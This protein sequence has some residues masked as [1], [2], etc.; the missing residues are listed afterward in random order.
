MTQPQPQLQPQTVAT[1]DDALAFLDSAVQVAPPTFNTS[2][3]APSVAAI[4]QRL[5]SVHVVTPKTPQ[6]INSLTR[7]DTDRMDPQVAKFFEDFKNLDVGS[8]EFQDQM[9]KVMAAG[10]R[11]ATSSLQLNSS[12]LKGNLTDV[13]TSPAAKALLELSAKFDELDPGKQGDFVK[14]GKILGIIPMP[15]YWRL[16]RYMKKYQA[17]DKTLRDLTGQLQ[18]FEHESMERLSEM[19]NVRKQMWRNIEKLGN[20]AYLKGQLVDKMKEYIAEVGQTDPHKAKVLNED[21]LYVLNQNL[22]DVLSAQMLAWNAYETLGVLIKSEQEISNA[23]NRMATYG[24]NAL[25]IGMLLARATVKQAETMKAVETARNTVHTMLSSQGQMMAEHVAQV[26]KFSE[27]PLFGVNELQKAME[28]TQKAAQQFAEFREKALPVQAENRKQM[29][30]FNQAQM[31]REETSRQAGRAI[32]EA[33]SGKR[34][35]DAVEL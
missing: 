8:E 31:R 16:K 10:N 34:A 6:Q 12:I 11:E 15:G 32:S 29:E 28:E 9:A 18:G 20:A 30:A 27:N 19:R 17:A 13:E 4:E 35:A 2:K 23:C 21:V 14:Q 26:V 3:E 7:V 5:D 33:T 24:M 1:A 25:E 22:N